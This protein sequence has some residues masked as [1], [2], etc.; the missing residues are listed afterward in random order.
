MWRERWEVL[1]PAASTWD[2][3]GSSGVHRSAKEKK[4]TRFSR[5]SEKGI[6]EVIVE[7][8]TSSRLARRSFVHAELPSFRLRA[9]WTCRAYMYQPEP[10]PEP[11]PSTVHRPPPPT[12]TH[13]L[14][15][16]LCAVFPKATAFPK[17]SPAL[18]FIRYKS[19]GKPQDAIQPRTRPQP[20][21][22]VAAKNM[23]KLGDI[24][25]LDGV[26]FSPTV[27][28]VKTNWLKEHSSCLPVRIC[29]GCSRGRGSGSL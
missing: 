7:I 23:E 4:Y 9:T 29:R 2:E 16:P 18:Q 11:P 1:K 14:L 6:S 21:P 3:C 15:R 28:G 13:C 8:N 24:G 17:A 12:M 25:L 26:W 20:S 27:L 22:Q 5:R 19:R 10:E